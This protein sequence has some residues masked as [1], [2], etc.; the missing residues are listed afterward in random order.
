MR[1]RC[2]IRHRVSTIC[3]RFNLF[4]SLYL[5]SPDYCVLSFSKCFHGRTFGSLSLTRSKPIHKLDI[6]AFDWPVAPFPILHYPLAEHEAEN[7]AEEQRCLAALEHILQVRVKTTE[8]GYCFLWD[9]ANPYP[10]P[11]F[12]HV[13]TFSD[14]CRRIRTPSLR[15]LSRASRQRAAITT[16]L[17]VSSEACVVLPKSTASQ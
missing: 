15:P 16:R 1:A 13:C 7:L 6:P 11:S 10:P 9:T 8:K 4:I 2:V 3:Y 12:S 14:F 17:S 5:G